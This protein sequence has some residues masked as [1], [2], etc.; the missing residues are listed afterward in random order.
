MRQSATP[1][2]AACLALA[3][4]LPSLSATAG[5]AAEQPT[6]ERGRNSLVTGLANGV[7][8]YRRTFRR[9][10]QVYPYVS[11]GLWPTVNLGVEVPLPLG[12]HHGLELYVGEGL[13]FE[14]HFVGATWLWHH[15]G[16]G[17]GG[18][19]AGVGAIYSPSQESCFLGC[20]QRG[21]YWIADLSVNVKF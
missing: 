17:Q 18:L 2:A 7:I 21:S 4:S 16:F 20:G 12:S 13:V 5:A 9:V 14:D 3:T 1:L 8:G 10:G 11:L 19:S 6:P 15:V